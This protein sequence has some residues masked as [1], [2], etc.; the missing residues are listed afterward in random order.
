ML[1]VA[2]PAFLSPY[3]GKDDADATQQDAGGILPPAKATPAE[4]SIA[5]VCAVF[6]AFA[7]ASAYATIRVIGRRVHS[8]VSVNYFAVM[9][10]VSSALIILIHP[11]LQFEIPQTAAQWYVSVHQITNCS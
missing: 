6:G 7:A 8:L 2:R 10:T 11:D 3:Y 4:R 9:A 1:F 5:I